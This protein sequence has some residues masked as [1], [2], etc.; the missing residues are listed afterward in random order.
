MRNALG[1][2][3]SLLVLGGGSEIGGAIAERLV[4]GGCRTVV[5]AGRNRETM[6]P[7]A[8]RLRAAGA[9]TV[10][11][12]DWDA[13]DVE[14]HAAAIDGI[15]STTGD[16][17]CV[18]LAAGVLGDQATFDADPVAAAAALT[19]NYT[20]P[21][22]TLLVVA[23]RFRQQGH[24]TLVVLSSVAGER[25][26]KSNFVYGSSKAALD[27]FAQGLGDALVADGIRVLIVRPGFVHSKMTEGRD[28]APLATTPDAVA[29]AVVEGLTK[30]REVIWV[31]GPLRAVMAAFRHLPRAVWRRV[32][33]RE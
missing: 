9:T 2:V 26:R 4:G 20:G 11:L 21:A 22:A 23:N 27:A 31:P 25:V 5:L 19:A 29:D 18:V 16:I 10:E 1:A 13:L 33:A 30:G 3:Q 15:W 6:E 7:V 8:Q 12:A 28:P 32:S 17:D 14:H 24:G